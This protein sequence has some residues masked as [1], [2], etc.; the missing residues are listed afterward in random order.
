MEVEQSD[1]IPD[2]PPDSGAKDDD[3]KEATQPGENPSPGHGRGSG[4]STR[5]GSKH[6]K[7]NRPRYPTRAPNRFLINHTEPDEDEQAERE[8]RLP[9]DDAA[10]RD[11]VL[12]YEKR[13]GRDAKPKDRYQRGYDVLSQDPAGKECKIEVKGLQGAWQGDA[14]VSMTGAQF[15]DARTKEGD[16]WLYVVENLG[17]DSPTVLPIHNPSRGTRAFYLY[18]DH[19]RGKVATK[20]PKPLPAPED[21]ED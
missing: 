20:A 14:T 7:G 21:D 10:A 11:V 19:W 17:T 4:E 2:E 13:E 15:D 3:E 5:P 16:W 12:A 8:R 6:P 1:Y 18:A 9:K